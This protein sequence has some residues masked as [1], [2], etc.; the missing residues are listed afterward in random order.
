VRDGLVQNEKQAAQVLKEFDVDNTVITSSE[1]GSTESGGAGVDYPYEDVHHPE[2]RPLQTAETDLPSYAISTNGP[3]EV[4]LAPETPMMYK[5]PLIA[6]EPK[7]EAVVK[8][9]A[10]A[11]S[12]SKYVK[13][14][15]MGMKL[16]VIAKKMVSDKVAAQL[17]DAVELLRA[18]TGTEQ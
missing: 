10:A 5:S 9:N 17:Q 13:L 8:S 12:I 18:S 3:P 11:A 4:L 14:L 7:I 2:P 16:E 15:G 1:R 6:D